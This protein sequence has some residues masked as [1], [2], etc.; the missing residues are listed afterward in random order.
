MGNNQV[1]FRLHFCLDV[2]A[3]NPCATS[4]H[5]VGIGIGQGNLFVGYL[6]EPSFVRATSSETPTPS[7]LAYAFQPMSFGISTRRFFLFYSYAAV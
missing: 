5:R 4:L 3:D 7:R 6:I 2:V 1:V